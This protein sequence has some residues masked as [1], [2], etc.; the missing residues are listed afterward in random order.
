MATRKIL[1]A[2]RS[3]AKTVEAEHYATF[4]SYVQGVAYQFVVTRAPG[5][6][7]SKI[8]HRKSGYSLGPV[9]SSHIAA[10]A[11]DYKEAG[12]LALVAILEKHGEA[13]VASSLRRI[14]L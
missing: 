13:R 14:E 11:F 6:S 12:K 9:E 10:A 4:T 1:V 7:G 2:D 3:G 5:E 8:T